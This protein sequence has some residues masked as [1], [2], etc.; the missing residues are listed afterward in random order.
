MESANRDARRRML[1]T[2][3]VSATTYGK[4]ID[5]TEV[6][7]G[8]PSRRSSKKKTS[9]YVAAGNSEQTSTTKIRYKSFFAYY[10]CYFM[11]VGSVSLFFLAICLALHFVRCL[12]LHSD[13]PV[14]TC[15]ADLPLGQS[16]RVPNFTLP[17]DD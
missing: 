14:L 4:D 1:S 8:A 12:I 7:G 9:L 11:F 2:A 6:Y 10:T 13:T 16:P 17:A 3:H 5:F 15:F